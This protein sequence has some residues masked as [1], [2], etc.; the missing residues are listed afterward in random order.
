MIQAPMLKPAPDISAGDQYNLG[1]LY[2]LC[3]VAAR[4]DIQAHSKT[5]SV[6]PGHES[7]KRSVG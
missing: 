6:W 1:R 5:A 2:C 7:R 4:G 3:A